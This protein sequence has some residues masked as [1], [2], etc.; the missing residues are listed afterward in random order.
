MTGKEIMTQAKREGRTLL[1]EIEAKEVLKEAG[2]SVVETKLAKTKEE[3][4]ADMYK[5]GEQAAYQVGVQGLHPELINCLGVLSIALA[6]VR[7]S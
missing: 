6:M 3:V 5:A 7:M 1:T 4:E 2:I